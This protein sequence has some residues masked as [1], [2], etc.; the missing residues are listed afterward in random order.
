MLRAKRVVLVASVCA[1]LVA[2]VLIVALHRIET[3]AV[4]KKI[5]SVI[6]G[7]TRPF[8]IFLPDSYQTHKSKRYPVIY[9]VDGERIRN[10][11]YAVMVGRMVLEQDFIL[12]AIDMIGKRSRDLRRE[13]ARAFNTDTSGEAGQ[14]TSFLAKELIPYIEANYR[15]SAE[16]ILAG[17]SYGG[18]FVV[19]TMTNRPDLFSGYLAFSPALNADMRSL[20]ELATFLQSPSAKNKSLYMNL[21]W[22]TMHEYDTRFE[23]AVNFITAKKPENFRFESNRY[24]LI[25]GAVPI[26]GY[27]EGLSFY[28]SDR[29]S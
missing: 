13:D 15:A 1:T 12:V 8:R 4:P 23:E 6:L 29:G 27:L 5:N 18:M 7:E 17:H 10:S 3:A 28:F 25:H 2:I 16:R 21:G 20:P 11:S 14:F 9:T 19:H 26:P 22:E 24:W